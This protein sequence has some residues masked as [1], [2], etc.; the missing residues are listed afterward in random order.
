MHSNGNSTHKSFE[1]L[2]WE[3]LM[4]FE[5]EKS[6]PLSL[7]EEDVKRYH[8]RTVLYK[9]DQGYQV[10][11]VPDA[12][13]NAS[14]LT[15]VLNDLA[16]ADL[17]RIGSRAYEI[18]AAGREELKQM[19]D[20]YHSLVEHYDVFAG[21]D[22]DRSAFLSSGDDP[23]EK[24]LIDGQE[25]DRFIDLRVAVMRFKGISPFD[26]VFLNLLR[27][28]RIGVDGNWEF[29]MAL[30]KELYKELEEI[31]NSAYTLQDLTNLRKQNDHGE[32][33]G[34]DII[35]DVILAGNALNEQR[36]Q[37]RQTQQLRQAPAPA[38]DSYA[39]TETYN[40]PM[41]VSYAYDPY[42]YYDHYRDPFYVE[43]CWRERR[44]YW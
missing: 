10:P 44:R 32:I 3:E 38:N 18:T 6:A 17:L 29:D 27:E 40:N 23:H 43:P 41:F 42:G 33:P 24:I 15:P 4:A 9:M 8:A 37:E 39:V 11:L 7:G 25:Y 28:G 20:Q 31:V 1:E 21:V 36:R 14:F 30:G 5:Q 12:N 34:S 16:T 35:K 19:A 13:S 2:T 26:M 22:L